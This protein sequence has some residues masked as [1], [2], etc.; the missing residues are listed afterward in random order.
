MDTLRYPQREKIKSIAEQANY[1]GNDSILLFTRINHPV[2]REQLINFFVSAEQ[3]RATTPRKVFTLDKYGEIVESVADP[4]VPLSREQIIFEFDGRIKRIVASTELD[5]DSIH[6]EPGADLV[7]GDAI[8]PFEWRDIRWTLNQSGVPSI[9]Q[10]SI[11]EAHEQGHILRPFEEHIRFYREYFQG[12]F[13][14]S[15]VILPE[16]E[17]LRRRAHKKENG[18][19]EPEDYDV[20]G[21]LSYIF[22]PTEITERM[23]QLKNYF[24]FKGDEVFTSA[25]LSYAREHYVDDTGLDNWMT[26]FFMAITPQT[27]KR[28]LEI[29]NNSGI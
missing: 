12:G 22:S 29:M 16:E 8:M 26:Q 27:E 7:T 24:G 20:Y 18:S 13:D 19:T 21:L 1:E 6:K 17:I 14:T 4:Y 3:A 11:I 23:S 10:K 2:I 15:K 28:F 9:K 5:I 25:H